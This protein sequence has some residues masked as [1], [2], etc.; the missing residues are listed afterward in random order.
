[1]AKRNKKAVEEDLRL[2]FLVAGDVL[3]TP[4]GEFREFFPAR[5]G[6]LVPE[7]PAVSNP[8]LRPNPQSDRRDSTHGKSPF[9]LDS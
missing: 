9:I 8:E 7:Q 6:C 5:H 3:P 1:M 4:R 2:T